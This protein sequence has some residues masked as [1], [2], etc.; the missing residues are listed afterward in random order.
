MA[1]LREMGIQPYGALPRSPEML[2][3]PAV[4]KRLGANPERVAD[5]IARMAEVGILLGYEVYP[6]Y[7]HLNLDVACWWL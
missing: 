3:A 6:N 2:K 7:R 4:A 1:I 5:R